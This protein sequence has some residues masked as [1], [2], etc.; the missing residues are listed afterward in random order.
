MSMKP[1][2]DDGLFFSAMQ[3]LSAADQCQAAED[4]A[5]YGVVLIE[6][7]ADGTVR[8]LPP[9]EVLI[10]DAVPTGKGLKP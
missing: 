1:V 5:V 4:L 10:A 3:G 8:L 9:S 7:M 6:T 2:D